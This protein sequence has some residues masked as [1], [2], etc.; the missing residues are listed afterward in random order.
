MG[1]VVAWAGVTLAGPIKVNKVPK[2]WENIP[3]GPPRPISKKIEFCKKFPTYCHTFITVR[4]NVSDTYRLKTIDRS[5]EFQGSVVAKGWLQID[6]N[7]K[8]FN[9]MACAPKAAI[10]SDGYRCEAHAPVPIDP[11]VKITQLNGWYQTP[12]SD[13]KEKRRIK[14]DQR[15][16]NRG[17]LF[18]LSSYKIAPLSKTNLTIIFPRPLM[19]EPPETHQLGPYGVGFYP[20]GSYSGRDE[21]LQNRF[22]VTPAMMENYVNQGYFTKTFSLHKK[23]GEF[24]ES[25]KV[26]IEIKFLAKVIEGKARN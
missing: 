21:R 24:E 11:S 3:G 8:S 14:C 26:T 17:F 13:Y 2:G 5:F 4:V 7:D 12:A 16:L 20:F 9:L 18:S 22:I 19:I 25:E 15:M 23:E 1:S 10:S 6:P